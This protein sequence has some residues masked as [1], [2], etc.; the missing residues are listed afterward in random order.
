MTALP[1]S[2]RPLPPP[3]WLGML[4]FIGLGLWHAYHRNWAKHRRINRWTLPIWLYVSVTGVL[5]YWLLY[6]H[7]PALNAR[8]T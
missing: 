7:F 5:I 8:A 1:T 6:H 3:T 4:P 2:A